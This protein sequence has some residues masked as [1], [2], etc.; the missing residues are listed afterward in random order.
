MLP[1]GCEGPVQGGKFASSW[2]IPR[3]GVVARL[4]ED[5]RYAHVPQAA[6]CMVMLWRPCEAGFGLAGIPSW[7]GLPPLHGPPPFVW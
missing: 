3:P 4:H 5:V 6:A 1:V 7:V 2:S